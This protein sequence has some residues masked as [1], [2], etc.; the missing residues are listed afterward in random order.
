MD[1]EQQ[2]QITEAEAAYAVWFHIHKDDIIP[3]GP[4]SL[5]LKK[6]FTEGY[7][8]GYSAGLEDAN[9]GA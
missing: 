8:A 9:S 1:S 3:A 4:M 2:Y 6:L 7:K 5:A